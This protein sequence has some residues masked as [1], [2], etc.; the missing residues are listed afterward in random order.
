[1]LPSLSQANFY[2]WDERRY[3][4]P[5]EYILLLK[6]KR[7]SILT[8]GFTSRGWFTIIPHYYRNKINALKQIIDYCS[9]FQLCGFYLDFPICYTDLLFWDDSGAASCSTSE[10]KKAFFRQCGHNK[11]SLICKILYVY[12]FNIWDVL[13]D[14]KYMYQHFEYPLAVLKLVY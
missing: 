4:N 2:L 7:Q 13:F 11:A 6:S 10:H 1:M 12:L 8:G 9:G 3:F 14:V 5:T